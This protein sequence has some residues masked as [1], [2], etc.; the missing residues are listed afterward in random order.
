MGVTAENSHLFPAHEN[1][2]DM[3]V[4]HFKKRFDNKCTQFEVLYNS[5]IFNVWN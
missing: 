1:I 3:V 2:I 4:C 5:E